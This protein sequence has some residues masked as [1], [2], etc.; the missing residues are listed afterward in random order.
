[1]SVCITIAPALVG[2]WVCTV[3]TATASYSASGHDSEAAQRNA[4]LKALSTPQ[5]YAALRHLID[6]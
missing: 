6:D 1:M 3:R 2:D 5:G 4:M